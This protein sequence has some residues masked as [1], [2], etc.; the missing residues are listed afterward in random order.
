M[1]PARHFVIAL[2][3]QLALLASG[4]AWAA[5]PL[6]LIVGGIDKQIYLPAKLAERLG[7]FTEEGLDVELRSERSGGNAKEQLLLG[8]VQGVVGFYDHTID[9]QAKGRQVQCVVQLALA[10]GEAVVAA[11]GAPGPLRGPVDFNGRPLG[12]TSLG[13]S[14]DFLMRYLA[15][16]AG[17][18]PSE[19]RTLGVG[20]GAEFKAALRTGRIHA[21]MT[22]EPTVSQL[23]QAGQARVLVDLRTPVATQQ[24]LGGP[25]PG[26]CL[27]M[28]RSWINAN[29]ALVQRLVNA[30]VRTLRYIGQHSAEDIAEL[31][32]A[33]YHG[34][35]KAT[36]VA[37]L[38]Q[39]KAMF[40]TD[41]RMPEDGPPTVLRIQMVANRAVQ[42]K[43]IDLSRT[44][45]N[46][47]A[48]AAAARWMHPRPSP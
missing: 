15:Y 3:L 40:T 26:A 2:A 19:A 37:A 9:M 25:Y 22:T 20:S 1:S 44:Y 10:P 13:S 48:A 23:V 31:M 38:Q 36:Y 45:T 17:L 39:T 30:L 35:D 5:Q 16:S 11:T 43:N 7:Y 18:R 27:Y 28:S 33:A 21:G 6:S 32:P 47:F 34:G 24:Q 42:G 46:G 8:A 41:G 29:Q 12:V 14:T 4:A